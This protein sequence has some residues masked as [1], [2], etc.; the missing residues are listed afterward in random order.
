MQQEF[1]H[2]KVVLITGG[3]MGIGKAL[4]EQILQKGGSVVV[5]GRNVARLNQLSENWPQYTERLL[6]VCMDVADEA[7][8]EKMMKAVKEKFGRL[9]A[10]IN[11]AALSAYGE[12]EKTE[13]SVIHT[14][15]DTNIKGLL[16]TTKAALPLLRESGG[17]VLFISSLA[18]LYG[19]PGYSLY[20][21]SK[22]ALSALR[23]SL[24]PEL[25]L[26]GVL[27]AIVYVGFTQN[28][29]DKRTLNANGEMEA[30]PARPA[31]LTFS[32]E[33][34]AALLLKQIENRKKVVIQGKIGKLTFI[35]ARYFPAVLG[36][37][38]HSNYRKSLKKP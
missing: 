33:K 24:T 27:P 7:G 14:L 23:Q 37:L 15:I 2:Q 34:T 20:S 21:L 4:A 30:V 31:N 18:G 13:A 38:L 9:D 32:R 17:V 12:L 35:L 16:F 3:S 28:E 6:T 1:Y 26:A 8:Q 19:L 29:S 5:T 11:N 10:L 25:E 22:M 36:V